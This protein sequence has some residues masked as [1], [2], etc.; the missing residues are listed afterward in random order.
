MRR[1]E[2]IQ[3]VL[4][5]FVRYKISPGITIRELRPGTATRSLVRVLPVVCVRI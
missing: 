3:R 2:I 4:C 5:N 1:N